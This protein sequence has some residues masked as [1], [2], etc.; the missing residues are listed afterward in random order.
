M[1]K[2]E[3]NNNEL[4]LLIKLIKG[5]HTYSAHT[6]DVVLD[7]IRTQLPEEFVEPKGELEK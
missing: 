7:A 1:Y 5:S 6:K 3:L 4:T 2:F